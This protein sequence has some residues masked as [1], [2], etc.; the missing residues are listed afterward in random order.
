M[1]NFMDGIYDSEK[2]CWIFPQPEKSTL[3][4]SSQIMFFS[5][6]YVATATELKYCTCWNWL[7]RVWKKAYLKY[8]LA[9]TINGRSETLEKDLLWIHTQFGN[10]VHNDNI[11]EAFYIVLETIKKILIRNH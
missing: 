6:N 8:G 10:T 2:N 5:N 11:E 4:M 1:A 3:P 9:D 7:I